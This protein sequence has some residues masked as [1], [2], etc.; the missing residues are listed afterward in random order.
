M[1]GFENGVMLAKNVNFDQA[2]P[3]P[4]LGIVDGAGK[5]IIGTGDSAPTPE[6]LAGSLTSPNGTITIGYVSPN[7]TL[8]L[9][10]GTTA[11]DS[12]GVD[13]TTATGT[14]P[15]LP[16]AAGEVVYTGGQYQSGTFG[17]R[18]VTINS[19]SPNNLQILSQISA[20]NASTL[21]TKNGIS[22]F[23]SARFTCDVNGF[24]SLNGTGVGETI[25]GDTGG[26]LSPTAGNWNI[27]GGTV[28]A[29]TSPLKTAGS[30]S[31]LTINAQISQALAATDAT[32]IGLSNFDS[33]SFS[34]DANGFVQLSGGGFTWNDISGAFSPL[35]N[36][37]YFVTGT[38][39][40]T[41]PAA[42]AQGDTIKFFVDH[43]SQVLTIQASG[44]QIIRLGSIV[45]SA[46]GT[47][48]STVQGDSVE[49]VYR[50][51]DTC[52]CAVTGI[53]GTWV[54]A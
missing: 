6:I 3:K 54:M 25:T 34:V 8:D 9:T 39:T 5:L 18:V 35:K 51:S 27:I 19:Q 32:K 38:A 33:T 29:G 37:G 36:N 48:V 22:H 42:P 47:A 16:D 21:V 12:I 43:A 28:V 52:W 45:S 46:G 26:A 44:T 49:L 2:A 1:A 17:T 30:G 31:T 20:T 41:L 24:V 4:H 10:G 11:I 40:G 13:T 14:N 23:D 53:I 50:T 15:V 7:I